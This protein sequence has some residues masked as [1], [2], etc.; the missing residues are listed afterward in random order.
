[1]SDIT[2]MKVQNI[3]FNKILGISLIACIP[4]LS[5]MITYHLVSGADW[6]LTGWGRSENSDKGSVSGISTES[7]FGA[8]SYLKTYY[9][10][11]TKI[12]ADFIGLN[13]DVVNVGVAGDG[14]L[15]TPKNWGQA[16]WYK[17]GTLSPTLRFFNCQ[18]AA[19]RP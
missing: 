16:G 19:G 15:E 4:I 12:I 11:P 6:S 14:P 3:L 18:K 13:L 1:M 2:V 10:A 8:D 7:V 5:F 9:Y 17:K